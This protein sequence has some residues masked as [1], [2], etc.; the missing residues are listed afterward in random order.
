MGKTLKK[1]RK[2]QKIVLA[3]DSV[4]IAGPKVDG[5]YSVTFGAGDQQSINVAKLLAIPQGIP[6]SVTIELDEREVEARP[7]VI[8]ANS[9]R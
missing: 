5:G 7:N 4:K 1:S 2:M 6:I 9:G 8:G 3:A